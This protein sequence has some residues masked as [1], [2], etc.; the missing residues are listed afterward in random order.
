MHIHADTEWAVILI[1]CADAQNVLRFPVEE[2]LP[3]LLLDCR[4]SGA[5]LTDVVQAR[6]V[7]WLRNQI[8]SEQIHEFLQIDIIP[9]Y[10]TSI[11]LANGQAGTL[12]LAKARKAPPVAATLP[13]L[14]DI[15]RSMPKDGSRM[16]VVRAWQV[17]A[18]AL[19]EETNAVVGEQFTKV[20][21]SLREELK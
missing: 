10:K 17:F 21:D 15:L 20:L 14:P 3:G 8:P 16:P 19:A 2:G 7:T 1:G 9:N 6:W 11:R 4:L 5:L 18:G 12:Y 13:N